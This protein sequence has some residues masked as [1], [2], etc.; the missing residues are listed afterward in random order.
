MWTLVD[1][2]CHLTL[3]LLRRHNI[4]QGFHVARYDTEE[5]INVLVRMPNQ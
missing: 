2:I 1:C 5:L 3:E 4:K